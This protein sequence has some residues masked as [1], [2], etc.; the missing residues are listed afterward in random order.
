VDTRPLLVRQSG[1]D[2]G[3]LPALLFRGYPNRRKNPAR[4]PHRGIR[5]RSKRKVHGPC[6]AWQIA[7]ASSL[8]NA[9]LGLNSSPWIATSDPRDLYH[10]VLVAI[11]PSLSLNNGQPSALA[12]WIHAL[13]LQRGQRVFHAGCGTGYYTAIMAEIVGTEGRVVAAEVEAALAVRATE[14]LADRDNVSVHQCDAADFDP[15]ESDAILI[16][17]GV[18]HPHKPWLDRLGPGGRMVLPI[19]FASPGAPHGAG[20][21]LK[22]VRE[23]KGFSAKVVSMVGIYS[24]ASVRDTA[25]EPMLQK[26]LASKMLMKVNSVR[27]D[28]HDNV[29][30][31]V[32]HGREVCLSTE[33]LK[34]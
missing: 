5:A 22:I 2:S 6:S 24:C 3:R 13:G 7:S 11:D 9:A 21:M 17:A 26:A 31:W 15:G 20:V 1:D 4:L 34:T 14:N 8:G 25:L 16:N 33:E 29:D 18:T 28:E 23:P 10:N 27:V 32:V 12:I 19:T 30:S